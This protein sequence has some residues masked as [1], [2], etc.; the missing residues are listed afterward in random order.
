[1]DI[2]LITQILFFCVVVIRVVFAINKNLEQWAVI[3]QK[4]IFRNSEKSEFTLNLSKAM[5][6]I[7]GIIIILLTGILLSIFLSSL[8][9]G[10]S[11]PK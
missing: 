6:I 5:I 7:S 3:I 11:I 1:M 4:Y 10:L 8:G 2:I 9:Y